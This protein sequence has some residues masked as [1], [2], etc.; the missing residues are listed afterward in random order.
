MKVMATGPLLTICNFVYEI[1][2]ITPFKVGTV[3]IYLKLSE[4]ASEIFCYPL[5]IMDTR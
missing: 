5:L 2:R 3:V 4:I 1:L